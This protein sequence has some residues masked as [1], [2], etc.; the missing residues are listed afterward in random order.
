MVSF[1]HIQ[2]L[3]LRE[4]NCFTK[5]NILIKVYD[6]Q[7]CASKYGQQTR[8]YGHKKLP[9]NILKDLYAD[10]Q[11]TLIKEI[12]GDAKKQKDSPCSWVGK[13]NIVKMAIL[14]KAIYRFNAI[15]IKLPMTFFTDLEQTI[16]NLI[17]SHKRPR[18]AKEILRNKNQAEGIT[19][20]D[21]R[22]YYKATV[23]KTVWS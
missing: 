1:L 17:W 9:K 6:S 22:Q 23:I 7:M 3:M 16:Q 21:F 10:N 12:K 8:F 2:I 13:N 19:L 14:P 4:V 5:A 18:I 11:K 15:P 20:T